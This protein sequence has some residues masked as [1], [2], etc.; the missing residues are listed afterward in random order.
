VPEKKDVA[1]KRFILGI[2]LALGLQGLVKQLNAKTN[3]V[4]NSLKYLQGKVVIIYY[5]RG[6]VD[7]LVFPGGKLDICRIN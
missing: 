6:K 3:S 4:A 1:L 2:L 7:I 5:R